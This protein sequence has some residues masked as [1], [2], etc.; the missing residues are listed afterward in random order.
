MKFIQII[1]LLYLI[2]FTYQSCRGHTAKD[3]CKT[4]NLSQGEKDDGAEY[5][6]FEK[7]ANVASKKDGNCVPL[8]KYQY[9]HIKDYIKRELI[10][11]S[12]EDYSI[13]C[14][15]F[16]LEISLLSLLLFLF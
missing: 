7:D 5:C 8:T 14:K 1:S 6:C 4:D 3:D 13:D 12:H 10:T 11:G 9:K 16:Y 2:S 15:S